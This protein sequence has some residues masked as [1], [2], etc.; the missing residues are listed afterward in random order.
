M[1]YN[2]Y[3]G[4]AKLGKKQSGGKKGGLKLEV[5]PSPMGIRVEP[6]IADELKVKVAKAV[7]AKERKA[8]KGD[9]R[10]TKGVMDDKDEFDL[11]NEDKG[12]NK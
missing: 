12:M 8:N 4:S 9:K 2:I 6:R 11:M 10:T 3:P 7:A 1:I 5:L